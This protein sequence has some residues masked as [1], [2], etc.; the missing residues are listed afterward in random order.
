MKM[1]EDFKKDINISLK[2]IQKNTSKQGEAL[3]KETNKSF[4]QIKNTNKQVKELN[5]KA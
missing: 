3:K 5:K 4:K 1:I 2:E